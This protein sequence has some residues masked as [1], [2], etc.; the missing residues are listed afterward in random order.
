MV[1]Q[2][3]SISFIVPAHN[4]ELWL[5]KCLESIRFA[6]ETISESYEVIVVNDA[7]TDSTSQIASEMADQTICVERRNIAAVRNVGAKAAQGDIFFFVDADTQVN[8]PAI[9]AALAALHAG[10]AGGGAVIDLDG[11][12][13]LWGR[14]VL[15]FAV[16]GGRIVRWTGG[17]FL[18]CTR[19]ACFAIGGFDESLYAGEDLAFVQAIKKVGR[20]NV[21]RPKVVTS[22]RKLAVV[23]PWQLIRLLLIIAVRGPRYESEWVWDI[24]YG[25]RAQEARRGNVSPTRNG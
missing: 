11:P 24:L 17:C 5:R 6:M 22:G 18:F 20:F 10:C 7:S 9:K 19:Q 23:R 15:F 8:V 21:L 2:V 25:K 16:A 4:E 12:V 13:P 14:I 1:P 3:P